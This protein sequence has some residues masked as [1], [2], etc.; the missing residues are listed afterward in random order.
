MICISVVSG[1]MARIDYSRL[2]CKSIVVIRK[3]HGALVI[4]LCDKT[5]SNT[6]GAI[7]RGEGVR[8]VVE[9]VQS[10]VVISKPQ[11]TVHAAVLEYFSSCPLPWSLL[12]LGA[13]T[14]IPCFVVSLSKE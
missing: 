5:G 14:P 3:Q 9:A 2:Q 7:N 11:S 6:P 12:Q 1:C 13:E 10:H 4:S 8:C